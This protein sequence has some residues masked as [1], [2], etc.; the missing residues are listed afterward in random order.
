MAGELQLNFG[1]G[2]TGEGQ[3]DAKLQEIG[4]QAEAVYAKIK[5]AQDSATVSDVEF[6]R[7]L[8]E[9]I[10]TLRGLGVSAEGVST[11]LAGMGLSAA[12]T[13]PI[14][15]KLYATATAGAAAAGAEI[16]SMALRLAESLKAA[17][18]SSAVAMRT[19]MGSLQLSAAEAG[20]AVQAVYGETIAAAQM[21]RAAQEAIAADT[22]RVIH[23]QFMA[24]A[25]EADAQQANRLTIQKAYGA[26]LNALYAEETAAY[27]ENERIRTKAVAEE[28]AQRYAVGKAQ[29]AA[30][31]EN[32]RLKTAAQRVEQEARAA[33][34]ARMMKAETAAYAE[35][36]ARFVA[37]EKA[38]GLATLESL[39]VQLAAVGVT[40]KLNAAQLLHLGTL[41][42][43]TSSL[44]TVSNGMSRA[45]AQ[46]LNWLNGLGR[47]VS[48]FI[49]GGGIIPT[50]DAAA[51]S[52]TKAQ[53]A[54]KELTEAQAAFRAISAT[55]AEATTA[56]AAAQARLA[57]ASQ[58]ATAAI[59]EATGAPLISA[60]TA[61]GGMTV[62]V[63]A[64]AGAEAYAASKA[65]SFGNELYKIQA[66]T[67]FSAR[68][69]SALNVIAAENGETLESLTT[70]IAR[71]GRNMEEGILR[72]TSEAGKVIRGLT[73]DSRELSELGLMTAEE[74]VRFLAVRIRELTDAGLRDAASQAL[75]GRG[76]AN[77]AEIIKDVAEDGYEKGLNKAIRAHLLLEDAQLE[78]MHQLDVAWQDFKL[79][80][81]GFI[82]DVGVGAVQKLQDIKLGLS[83]VSD[84]AKDAKNYVIQLGEAIANL[85]GISTLAILATAVGRL[86]PYF[87]QL[88]PYVR[89][90]YQVLSSPLTS[91][92]KYY[93]DL[94]D[95]V[96]TLY[97]RYV[98]SNAEIQHQSDLLIR[99]Q[100][101]TSGYA[102]TMAKIGA[103]KEYA[104]EH[105]VGL[106][107]AIY[108]VA[109]GLGDADERLKGFL[110]TAT[111][112]T[113]SYTD[114]LATMLERIRAVVAEEESSD[115]PAKQK[116]VE[117]INKQIIAADALLAKDAQRASRGKESRA[118]YETAVREH[119][120]IIALLHRELQN[121]L[122]ALDKVEE[123]R[124]N[125]S[126]T[127][128]RENLAKE[129]EAREKSARAA[130]DKSDEIVRAAEKEA[131]VEQTKAAEA[132]AV[133]QKNEV[134]RI[135]IAA[136]AHREEL[137]IKSSE[138]AAAAAWAEGVA[139]ANLV[140][141]TSDRMLA[142]GRLQ[143]H[144]NQNTG[145][146]TF[147]PAKAAADTARVVEL[148]AQEA[149]AVGLL[150]QAYQNEARIA[151]G[152]QR[153]ISASL[154]HEVADTNSAVNKMIADLK[155]KGNEETAAY[156]RVA[157][158]GAQALSRLQRELAA[159][160]LR[161]QELQK[162]ISIA[163]T[164]AMTLQQ[165]AM[166]EMG[167]AMATQDEATRMN[168]LVDAIHK[169]TLATQLSTEADKEAAKAKRELQL[170][171]AEA[172]AGAAASLLT[173]LGQKKAAAYVEMVMQTAAGIAELAWG[174][175]WKAAIHFMSAAEYGIIAGQ[176]DSHPGAGGAG[177]GVATA[178]VTTTSQALAPGA[179]GSAAAAAKGQSNLPT[180]VTV[181]FHGPVYGGK[182]GLNELTNA[183]SNA[184]RFGDATLYASHATGVK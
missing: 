48:I 89:E 150:N 44:R 161:D 61:I 91:P 37:A 126:I 109:H 134:A 51:A 149:R 64:Y 178:S 105:H 151:L 127:K 69:L 113:G 116:I 136:T 15:A 141:I 165:E 29:V 59:S 119:T 3:V 90:F 101:A 88:L 155:K 124:M 170:A 95:R 28:T 50:T 46:T 117:A 60:G 86:V 120:E 53:L 19:I 68:T 121:K 27:I 98:R 156:E 22:A 36:T 58:A 23:D 47:L 146:L 100:Y 4:V 128:L 110:A 41:N 125:K 71:A 30:F 1:F 31:A 181:N 55:S 38:K 108:D 140:V 43:L 184:V 174:N 159:L 17:G 10:V 154:Q 72:P 57:T 162:S 82:I 102:D 42:R 26:R 114:A 106:G 33:D 107:Q 6:N 183:I 32:E 9:S 74:R 168:L 147:D 129:D 164:N 92:L 12:S 118:Q 153:Q 7:I 138:Q 21:S 175:Y 152:A 49:G 54:M 115:L 179:A 20:A 67:G 148:K 65:I 84:W 85:P 76:W 157:T 14:I 40:K 143:A 130:V 180:T 39:K 45:T 18:E 34:I 133:E 112:G 182:Q 87:A 79:T 56:L 62:A 83:L 63:L 13:E 94:A 25:A 167:L 160:K 158:P 139:A 144:I 166:A 173:T 77:M 73:K 24:L 96:G 80:L 171:E 11:G 16:N 70:T 52:F 104:I 137:E 35:N 81:K 172:V 103:A 99:A 75:F 163:R 169:V 93:S 131:R 142:E 132:L 2:A 177:S 111:K 135:A 8:Q 123:D 5:A 176:T 97:D 66:V 122:G 78:Q 145:E